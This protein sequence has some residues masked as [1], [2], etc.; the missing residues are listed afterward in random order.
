MVATDTVDVAAVSAI[1]LACAQRGI[2]TAGLVISD[3]G[4]TERATSALRP[5]ARVIMVTRDEH[6]VTEILTALRA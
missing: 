6:D 4:A 2:M 3:G 1:G 5:Y